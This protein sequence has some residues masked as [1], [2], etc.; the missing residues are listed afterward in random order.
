MSAA[1]PPRRVGFDRPLTT[2]QVAS[3]VGNALATGLFYGLVSFVLL[4]QRKRC[5]EGALAY[6]VLP[7]AFCVCVGLCC[8]LFLETHPPT[9]PSCFSKFLPETERWT[10]ARYCREHKSV[11][12][13]L[14]HFCTWLNVSVGRSNYV[15]FFAVAAFG[16]VQ[17][18]VAAGGRPASR[19]LRVSCR[20]RRT[21]LGACAFVVASCRGSL[22]A[23]AIVLFGA[24]GVASLCIFL[25]YASLF[26]FHAYLAVLGMG[27]YD[28]ILAQ[29]AEPPKPATE[30]VAK[31]ARVAQEEDA[32]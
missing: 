4:R 9:E 25:A 3:W 11:V 21:L 18:A 6:A 12:A 29:R 7:H 20:K 30:L 5:D 19:E 23:A 15:P 27:T 22:H 10:K 16:T 17:Y 28:W 14:D 24:C 26:A 31:G 32:A 1:R 8:W 13:G 2:N